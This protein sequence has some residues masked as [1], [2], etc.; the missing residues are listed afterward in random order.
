MDA[1]VIA[2]EEYVLQHKLLVRD[3]NWGSEKGVYIEKKGLKTN[4]AEYKGN[5]QWLDEEL[6]E[7]NNAKIC[8][9]TKGHCVWRKEWL[10]VDWK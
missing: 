9:S 3:I 4:R 7:V 6:E 2:G 5:I 1:K 10:E 8:G